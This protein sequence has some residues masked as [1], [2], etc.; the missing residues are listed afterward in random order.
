[1]PWKQIQTESQL[2]WSNVCLPFRKQRLD[3][4]PGWGLRGE[5]PH[6]NLSCPGA[7]AEK[8][9]WTCVQ[10]FALCFLCKFNHWIIWPYLFICF[11]QPIFEAWSAASCILPANIQLTVSTDF[12]I[13][14]KFMNED[15]HTYA[16]THRC[17]WGKVPRLPLRAVAFGETSPMTNSY[18][19][20]PFCK[21]VCPRGVCVYL[22]EERGSEIW[23]QVINAEREPTNSQL[24]AFDRIARDGCWYQMSTGTL[25][26]LYVNLICIESEHTVSLLSN[27]N[28]H[29][30]LIDEYP[31]QKTSFALICPI[32]I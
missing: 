13:Y 18:L 14:T 3:V 16:Q 24:S 12:T 17:S 11:K 28:V 9:T 31:V 23:S 2:F 22:H 32:V 20:G 5:K 7:G 15:I 26:C 19:F 8:K 6:V 1:M 25:I 21:F 30:I 4:K 29:H 27:L 10:I